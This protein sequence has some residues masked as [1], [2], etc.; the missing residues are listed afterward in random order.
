MT[1]TSET[2]LLPGE[3]K[4]EFLAL[5]ERIAQEIEP[6]GEIE[7][8]F[9]NDILELLWEIMR[10]RRYRTLIICNTIPAA[11][12]SMM[13]QLC[14]NHDFL[15]HTQVAADA[16]AAAKDYFRN[17]KFKNKFLKILRE[18]GFD[19]RALEAEAFRLAISDLEKLDKMLSALEW[20]R[21]KAL[22]FIAEYRQSLSAQIRQVTDQTL[23]E[24]D[25][26]RV[27]PSKSAAHV[28]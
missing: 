16:V 23:A 26:P 5:R 25:R 22:R 20:R 1:T 18:A 10:L 8:T 14:Y 17:E 11:V 6:K 21:N 4:V 27:E 12:Q 7:W 3:S 2:F 9:L 15:A 24:I 19:D 13:K 28:D